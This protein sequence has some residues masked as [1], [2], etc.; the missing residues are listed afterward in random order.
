[1][2]QIQVFLKS[3]ADHTS[4][5]LYSA[6]HHFNF[7][8]VGEADGCLK[9]SLDNIYRLENLD[10]ITLTRVAD[11]KEELFREDYQSDK[12][13]YW[14]DVKPEEVEVDPAIGVRQHLLSLLEEEIGQALEVYRIHLENHHW[15]STIS[16]TELLFRTKSGQYLLS[17]Q[18]HD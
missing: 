2:E 3:L 7:Y 13:Y 16:Y 18:A 9:R 5:R 17:F 4:S 15:Y 1:M 12:D 14:I 10:D 8:R 11:W 6:S